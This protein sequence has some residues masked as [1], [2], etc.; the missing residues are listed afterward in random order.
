MVRHISRKYKKVNK[1]K[2]KKVSHRK[3]KKTHRRKHKGGNDDKKRTR[4][5]TTITNMSEPKK[6]KDDSPRSVIDIRSTNPSP[7][8]VEP[9][10]N[11]MMMGLSLRPPT[12]RTLE[13]L[14]EEKEI[15]ERMIL[16]NEFR[17]KEAERKVKERRETIQK[18]RKEMEEKKRKE[19]EDDWSK[20]TAKEKREKRNELDFKKHEKEEQ[21]IEREKERL[22]EKKIL[23]NYGKKMYLDPE[24][25]SLGNPV[26][27]FGQ[28]TTKYADDYGEGITFGGKKKKGKYFF[29]LIS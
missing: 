9:S 1:R 20:L 25:P 28:P 16:D 6:F 2:S 29:F 8:N 13:K 11:K 27:P 26:H 21:E 7:T 24:E 18:L 5:K 23:E 15:R 14:E 4:S 3:H 17:E 19:N 22:V 10:I 12:S